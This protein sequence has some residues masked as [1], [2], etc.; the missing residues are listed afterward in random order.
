MKHAKA[1]PRAVSTDTGG[2]DNY[3]KVKTA[4]D[5][6]QAGLCKPLTSDIL[7]WADNMGFRKADDR[8]VPS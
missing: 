7:N 5:H 6:Q 2:W 1:N 4:L 3:N 8:G